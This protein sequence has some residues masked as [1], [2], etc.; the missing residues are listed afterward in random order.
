MSWLR[1]LAFWPPEP[2]PVDWK[3]KLRSALAAC[4]A[5]FLTGLISSRF[6]EGGGLQ[7]L[8]ASMGASAVILFAVPHSPMARG[9]PLVA[10]HLLSGFIGVLTARLVSDVWPAAAISVGL[11]IF[12]MHISRCLH[13]P[14]GASALIPVLGGEQIKG[15]GF[16]FLLTPLAL[17]VTAMLLLSLVLNRLN[18]QRTHAGGTKHAR[19]PQADL[20]PLERLGIRTEDL[21]AAL[22]DMNA[23]VDVS[24]NDLNEIYDLAA[25]RAYRREFGEL[26]CARI[27]TREVMTVEFGTDLEETWKLMRDQGVKA[28]PVID[29]ARHV[30]GIITLTDFFRHARLERFDGLTGKLRQLIRRTPTVTSRKPEVAGQI[31]TAP[32]ITVREDS[33]I[34][35]LAPLLCQRGIHQVPVVDG[36]NKLVGLVTQSDLI[37]AMYRKLEPAFPPP[38]GRHSGTPTANHTP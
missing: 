9:W 32:V 29:R 31:M 35:D 37:A 2:T 36:R 12:L 8:V 21:R 6:I 14:G 38:A 27:M 10:G 24:E 4:L 3:E 20:P 19:A 5:I 28:I 7:T 22:R 26:N 33:P 18:E 15:L 16:E 13:P 34:A 17:N 30:I 25:H 11:A 1:R 23:F